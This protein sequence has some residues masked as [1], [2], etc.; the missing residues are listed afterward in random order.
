[1]LDQD[2]FLIIGMDIVYE[3]QQAKEA[4]DRHR[5]ELKANRRR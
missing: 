1:M 2:C 5:E 4:E 3:E